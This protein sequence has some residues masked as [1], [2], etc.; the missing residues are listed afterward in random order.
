MELVSPDQLIHMH[1]SCVKHTTCTY[2]VQ[3]RAKNHKRHLSSYDSSCNTDIC[4]QVNAPVRQGL[5]KILLS[6]CKALISFRSVWRSIMAFK[7]WGQLIS[8]ITLQ[9]LFT[10]REV[11]EKLP[12]LS[13]VIGLRPLS[14][15]LSMEFQCA[16]HK[17]LQETITPAPCLL[18]AALHSQILSSM[19]LPQK[20]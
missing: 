16:A 6:Q 1:G 4:T 5:I 2:T 20:V 7:Q 9:A 14:L 15:N 13:A 11:R 10:T 3:L 8:A 18:H 12:L 19:L 17:R